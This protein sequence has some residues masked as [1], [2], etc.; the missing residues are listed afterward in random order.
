MGPLLEGAHFLFNGKPMNNSY[1]TCIP[2]KDGNEYQGFHL[3]ELRVYT[4]QQA[5]AVAA[6]INGHAFYCEYG[7]C[8]HVGR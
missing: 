7:D 1:Q 2:D 6:R 4:E 3:K 5:R 8:W